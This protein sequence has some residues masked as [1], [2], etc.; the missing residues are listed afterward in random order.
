MSEKFDTW[1]IVDLFG[2]QKIAG[3][4]SEEV[5]AGVTF[6]RMDV[7]ET[8]GTEAFTR[9]YGGS[10]IYSITPVSEEIARRAAE[11]L[12]REPITVWMPDFDRRALP[13][14][15]E[16]DDDEFDEE[17]FEHDGPEILED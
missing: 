7:P 15:A 14:G 5:V 13:V 4:A 17:H 3:R 16:P 11:Q 9:F 1:A 2:H 10:S 6:L 12:R 8:S